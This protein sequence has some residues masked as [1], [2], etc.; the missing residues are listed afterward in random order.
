MGRTHL[1]VAAAEHPVRWWTVYGGW[2]A[3]RPRLA[4]QLGATRCT[5]VHVEV[6]EPLRDGQSYDV[7]A[8]MLPPGPEPG[9]SVEV[10]LASAGEVCVH[11]TLVLQVGDQQG[12]RS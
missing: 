8:R 3:I 9:F 1:T 6:R 4:R 2:E 12:E 10:E 7:V 11:T 5:D